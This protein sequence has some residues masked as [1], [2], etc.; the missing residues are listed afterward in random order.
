MMPNAMP[1]RAPVVLKRRL[2]EFGDGAIIFD[3]KNLRHRESAES[4][5]QNRVCDGTSP[6]RAQAM[7]RIAVR[8]RGDV[9]KV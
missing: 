4:N 3:H 9:S 5:Q 7:V 6:N 1:V 2:Q 8:R